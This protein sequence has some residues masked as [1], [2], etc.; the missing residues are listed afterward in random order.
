MGRKYFV[1]SG[2]NNQGP[3]ELEM[4][5]SKV[6]ENTLKATD[7]I[8]IDEKEEWV[9]ICQHPEFTNIFSGQEPEKP[10]NHTNG[11][12][13]HH[14]SEQAEWYVLKDKNRFGPLSFADVVKMLQD[15]SLFEYD[16]AWRNGMENWQRIAE[17][18]DFSHDRIRVLFENAPSSS[19]VFFRRKFKRT[20]YECQVVI[21]DNSKV[22]KGN[23]MELSEGGAS[24]VMENAMLLP[25][26]SIYVHFKPGPATKPFNVL[27]EIVNKRFQKGVK[28]AGSPLV[29]GVRFINIHKQDRDDIK[30]SSS[31][32]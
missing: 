10:V 1:N 17:L 9:L 12:A 23:T 27:C 4:I 11:K 7:Y 13:D 31:A 24:L 14:P 21:H 18:A 29:Y 32:A 20:P 8:Y 3:F 22:W 5:V 19:E 26:Q 15:K 2:G 28:D 6:K 30:M 16:Y 25:G